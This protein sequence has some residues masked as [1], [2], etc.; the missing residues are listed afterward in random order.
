VQALGEGKTYDRDVCGTAAL[1]RPR[2]KLGAAHQSGDVMETNEGKRL[3]GG[4]F[5][6]RAD[7]ERRSLRRPLSREN[8]TAQPDA[9]TGAWEDT[10]LDARLPRV[11]RVRIIQY[12]KARGCRGSY[13]RRPTF[14]ARL[15]L[16]RPR[17]S[18]QQIAHKFVRDIV[19]PRERL[20]QVATLRGQAAAASHR[21]VCRCA[22]TRARIRSEKRFRDDPHPLRGPQLAARCP[23]LARDDAARARYRRKTSAGNNP[24]IAGQKRTTCA[25]A[26]PPTFARS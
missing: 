15:G 26:A 19:R 12:S 18:P 4:A 9:G 24:D 25:S 6:Q 13:S 22:E 8:A 20:G 1:H 11:P 2:R 14:I 16:L 23:L 7:S 5:G 3:G 21:P 10:I 17:R